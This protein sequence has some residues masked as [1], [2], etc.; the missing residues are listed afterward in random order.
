LRGGEER[1]REFPYIG[2]E[3]LERFERLLELSA[4]EDV[5]KGDRVLATRAVQREARRRDP[6]ADARVSRLIAAHERSLMR[7]ALHWSLCRD[8]ALDAYQR[9]LEI[10]VRRLDSLDPATEIAWMKVVVKHEA[11]AVRRGRV[12]VVPVEDVDFDGRAAEAQRPVDDLLAGRE[13][14]KR[15]AEALRRLKPDEAKALMLKAQGLSYAEI[16]ESLGWTYT[17][18]NR[19]I[20]E[21]RA[22]F[23]KV[24]AEIEAGEECDRVAPTLAALVGG[25]A[26]AEALL[27]L[28]PHLRHCATCRAT[29]RELHATRLGRLA[30]LWPLPALVAPLRWAS[31]RFG[32]GV[33]VPGPDGI[34]LGPGSDAPLEL[35]PVE[36][37]PDI[38][39]LI[40]PLELPARGAGEQSGRLVDL[41]VQAY[42]WLH[43]LHGTDVTTGAQIAAGTG[44]GRIATIGAVIGLCLSSL[45]A[46]TVCLV[47]GVVQNPFAPERSNPAAV[48]PEPRA[49]PAERRRRPNPARPPA[50]SATPAPAAASRSDPEPQRRRRISERS[51]RATATEHE[52]PPAVPAPAGTSQDFSF[53]Q[54]A[55]AA[56]AAPAAAPS[57]G[58][59][60]FAP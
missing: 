57:N 21:G 31:A 47:T 37:L 2:W 48:R 9:A 8:D 14:V 60:E 17:K 22:R 33:P 27:E 7:V 42:Q 29:V 1:R 18:V 20:T 43:R 10:Y 40:A 59:G 6:A 46:G 51:A 34:V 58:G 15:S 32:E 45:G 4:F 39:D 5:E 41:K 53:E 50:V 26:S 25:T 49:T 55:P 16:G 11:L 30:A 52:Q 12:E 13:R 54:T 38:Y 3:P 44:G 35:G 56:P 24:Y 36:G 23:L 28:R 19:C